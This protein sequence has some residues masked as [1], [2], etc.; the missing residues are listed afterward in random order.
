MDGRRKERFG[1]LLALNCAHVAQELRVQAD[2]RLDG[3]F[4]RPR[5]FARLAQR[6][7]PRH[8]GVHKGVGVGHAEGDEGD[9]GGQ[10]DAQE[11]EIRDLTADR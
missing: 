8:C 6:R 3:H 2:D 4:Q 5:L 9:D 10:G 1:R 11:G 7:L